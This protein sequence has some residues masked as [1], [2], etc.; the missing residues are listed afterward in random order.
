MKLQPKSKNVPRSAW[1][2]GVLLECGSHF[3]G[4]W[5]SKSPSLRGFL[6]G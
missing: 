2:T 6:E 3:W 1:V 4:D 5:A